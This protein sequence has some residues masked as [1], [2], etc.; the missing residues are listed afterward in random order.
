MERDQGRIDAEHLR[1]LAIFHFVAAG[2][3]ALGLLFVGVHFALFHLVFSHPEMWDKSKQAPPPAELF[4][5]FRW[6][7]VVFV[8]WFLG[9]GIVNLLSG[10]F[11]RARRH[12]VFSMVVAGLNCVYMP[13]GTVLGVFTLLVLV[14][15]S[16]RDSYASGQT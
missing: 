9:S 14:R 11:L 1:L 16:V 15:D 8:V 12:R 13:L 5:I 4:A 10:L 6:F 2:L 3:A 7:Y